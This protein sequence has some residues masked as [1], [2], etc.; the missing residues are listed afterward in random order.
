M[1]ACDAA[2]AGG[3]SCSCCS[4]ASLSGWKVLPLKVCQLSAGSRCTA[5]EAVGE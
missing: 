5:D 2:P 3:S 4:G 1:L